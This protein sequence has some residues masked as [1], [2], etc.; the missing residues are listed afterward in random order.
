MRVGYCR[1][2][3]AT[4]YLRAARLYKTKLGDGSYDEVYE[5]LVKWLM[6][7]QNDKEKNG[8][9]TFP[10]YL[11]D[12]CKDRKVMQMLF[13]NDNGKI[14]LNLALLY[15]E[16]K[17]KRLL[18]MAEKSAD[19]WLSVQRENGTY[20]H[21]CLNIG[22]PDSAGPCF[23]LWPMAAFFALYKA[24]GEEKYKASGEKAFAHMK[25]L[26]TNGRLRTSY[27]IAET[28]AWRPV[29]SEHYIA[30]LCY[31]ISY[32]LLGDQRFLTEAEEL[33]PYAETFV[34]GETGAIKNCAEE[35]KTLSLNDNPDL[36]DL[37]YTQ[38]FA[39]NAFAELY[40]ATKEE[41]FLARAQKLA[42]FLADIQCKNDLPC[43]N[44][45]WRGSYNLKSN[46]YDGRCNQRNDL[47]E[48][49]QYS[50]YTGWCALPIAFGML[51]LL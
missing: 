50:V 9:E 47:D 10:F 30:L 32:N 43:V 49:G 38:G 24:T 51:K 15:L 42:E 6:F 44:G 25:T 13:Q 48:G 41:K 29:S 3:T 17:D 16:T 28:E 37:V 14:M 18:D 8:N 21:P 34:D 23:V 1:P 40:F 11:A 46:R 26:K 7:A 4:E 35:D 22:E 33:L 5:N 2:D 39:L 12:G 36:C 20:Y 19:F 45:G 27:E 31:A